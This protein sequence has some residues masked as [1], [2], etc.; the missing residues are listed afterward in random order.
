MGG[1][2]SCSAKNPTVQQVWSAV[3]SLFICAYTEQKCV[4]MRAKVQVKCLCAKKKKSVRDVA[5]AAAA[6]SVFAGRNKS[7][8]EKCVG[9]FFL[10]FFLQ[11]SGNSGQVRKGVFLE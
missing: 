9:F 3:A 10:S 1:R 8:A 5:A 4:Y 2:K 11:R 6:L 7:E